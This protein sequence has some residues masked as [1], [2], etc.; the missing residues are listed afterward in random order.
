MKS[1]LSR[2]TLTFTTKTK[3]TYKVVFFRDDPKDYEDHH[4]EEVRYPCDGPYTEKQVDFLF[5]EALYCDYMWQKDEALK[6]L[7]R[8]A[9]IY[10]PSP[11]PGENEHE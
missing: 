11:E 3:S 8:L 10:A 7:T 2:A 1:I 6:I 5:E 9:R 4:K